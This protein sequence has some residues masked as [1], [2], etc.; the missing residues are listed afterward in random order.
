MISLGSASRGHAALHVKHAE[1]NHM[2]GL[3]SALSPR[4]SWTSRI[5]LLGKAL[6]CAVRG[7]LAVHEPHW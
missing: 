3:R 5:V 7:Q 2:S 1:H 4:P 6:I